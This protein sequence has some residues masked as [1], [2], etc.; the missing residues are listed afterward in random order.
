M[1]DR[2]LKFTAL[3]NYWGDS[4]SGN[5]WTDP[6]PRATDVLAERARRLEA[7]GF[8]SLSYAEFL[9]GDVF[10]P[11]MEIA[12]ATERIE[13]LTRV[14]GAFSRSPV[15][16]ASAAAWVAEASGGRFR[17]GIGASVPHEAQ[18]YLGVVFDR[19]AARMRDTIIIL[20][21]LW[22]EELPGVTRLAS[23][24]VRY[25]GAVVQVETA[26]VDLRPR[27]PI[28]L[29]LAAAGPLMLRLAGELADGVILELTT[30]AYVRWAWQE[31]RR[32]AAR[33]GRD[34]SRFELC[35]QGTWV[36]D[37]APAET[38]RRSLRFHIT[39]CVD[40]EFAPIWERGGLAEEAAAIRERA[41][42]GDW[43][44]AERLT[45]ERLWPK[46]AIRARDPATLW[47]WLEGHRAVGVTTFALPPNVEELT[48]ISLEEIRRRTAAMPVLAPF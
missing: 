5:D 10:P 39:H 13:L 28:P 45:E 6:R 21:A 42:A 38:R 40:K 46:L 27:R 33:T 47:R 34:L 26:R 18:E 43:Q 7:I 36:N 44:G 3:A 22:G 41:L 48:G 23:G 2:P 15:L 29:L 4:P 24:Q 20:R 25:P 32:G 12:R 16:L 37:E 9:E 19:P 8:D 30:P 35:V 1:G 14:A 11:L 17:L 31:I